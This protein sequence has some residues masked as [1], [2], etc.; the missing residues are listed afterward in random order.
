VEIRPEHFQI[1][2]DEDRCRMRVVEVVNETI[3]REGIY[4]MQPVS[5]KCGPD[6]E[7]DILLGAVL[8]KSQVRPEPGRFLVKGV[9]LRQGAVA[10][11]L[12]WDTNNVLAIGTSEGEMAAAVTA[13]ADMGGGVVVVRDGREM[14]RFPLPLCGV[15]SPEPL[16]EIVREMGEVEA[17]CRRLGS[18]LSRPLLTLQTLPFTGLPFLR[19]TDKGLADIRKGRLVPLFS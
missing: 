10:T 13:L 1:R 17:A 12:I 7:R 14:A 19:P 16:P 2:T 6:M 4:E 11:S 15:I 3:T 5:G 18:H 8:N 9:G